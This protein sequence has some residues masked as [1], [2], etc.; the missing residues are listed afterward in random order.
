MNT[1]Y[2]KDYIISGGIVLEKKQQESKINDYF[3]KNICE[4][5]E[6]YVNSLIIKNKTK[7]IKK[8]IIKQNI[9]KQNILS[10]LQYNN[11]YK[12][13]YTIYPYNQHNSKKNLKVIQPLS[14][15]KEIKQIKQIK[16]TQINKKDI[17][18]KKINYMLKRLLN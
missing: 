4:L 6:D 11:N 10:S 5:Q 18:K 2:I 16:K 3:S 9:L 12:Q 15:I 1:H 8:N 17:D 14:P 7:I 13:K